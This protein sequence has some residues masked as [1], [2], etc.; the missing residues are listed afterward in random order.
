M[1]LKSLFTA[2]A[3]LSLTACASTTKAPIPANL[4]AECKAPLTLQEGA[5]M[6]DLLE[7]AIETNYR[8]LDC[9]ER[10]KALSK[11]VK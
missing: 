7:A 5:N 4:T 3:L 10:H 2:I 6:G 1:R 8:L 11:L 9:S